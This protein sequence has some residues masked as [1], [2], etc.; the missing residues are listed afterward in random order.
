ML[1]PVSEVAQAFGVR[2]V[3]A[4]VIL[5]KINDDIM[6]DSEKGVVIK[7]G[8]EI[9][10]IHQEA[11]DNVDK[12][13]GEGKSHSFNIFD[14]ICGIYHLYNGEQLVYIGKSTNL[15]SRLGAHVGSDKVFDSFT[16]RNMPEDEITTAEIYAICHHRPMYNIAVGSPKTLLAYIAKGIKYDSWDLYDNP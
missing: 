6:C 11:M 8:D 14:K 3:D 15:P 7:N 2:T 4:I 5:S 12:D 9:I 10:E 1:V 13:P 16:V